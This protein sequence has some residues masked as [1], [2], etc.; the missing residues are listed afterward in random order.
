MSR[1]V[2]QETGEEVK[3]LHHGFEI[4]IIQHDSG[5][6]ECLSCKE[7]GIKNRERP[8]RKKYRY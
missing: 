2:I 4:V 7:V 8:I 5:K 6:Q 3:L 1:V